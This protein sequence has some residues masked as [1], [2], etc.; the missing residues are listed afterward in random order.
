MLGSDYAG[1]FEI[2]GDVSSRFRLWGRPVYLAADGFVVS[3]MPD[4]F[5]RRY[6]SNHFD[7][8]NAF[9]NE[10]KTRIS[11]SLSIP[12]LGFDLSAGV[13]NISNYVYFDRKALP[14]QYDGQIQVL[15]AAWKQHLGYG[16]INLDNEAVFQLSGKE[17]ILPLP[18]LSLYTNLYA[19]PSCL[20]S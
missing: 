9:R 13:E 6:Y 20:M 11:G 15:F 16:I 2:K 19:K 5:L 4:Y 14:A 12:A 1:N 18:R 17:E 3:R 10:Y 7:W 8:N